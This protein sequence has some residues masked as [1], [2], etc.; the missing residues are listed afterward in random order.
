MKS[1]EKIPTSKVQRAS[2]FITTGAKIGRNYVKHYA[3]KAVNKNVTREELDEDNA[4][5]IYDSLSQLK[6]SALKVAQMMSMDKNM[7]P[8]AYTDRFTMSQYSAPPL[9]GPLVVKTFKKYFGKS[10]QELYDS[11]EM[12]A[13]NAASIGQV[14]TAYKDGK[15]L[16]VKIQY[17]GVADSIHSDLKMVK[18]FAVQILQLP[19]K[20]IDKYLE[21]VE[22]KLVEETDY[23]LELKRSQEISEACAHLD[24]LAFAHYY[25]DLSA[26]KILTMDWLPGK[27]LKEFMATNPSQEIRNQIGQALWD[28]YDFQMHQ[29]K[30]VHADPHP[31]NF[32]LQEDGTLGII[33]F[34]CI[35]EIPEDFYHNYFVVINPH[36]ME[37][38]EMMYQVFYDME[39]LYKHD[40][41]HI[42]EFYVGIFKQMVDL[43]CRP[44]RTDTFDFS[45]D[46]YFTEIYEFSDSLSNMKEIR[47]SKEA[48]GSKHSLY[49]N[50][51]YFGL[52][53]ILNELKAEVITKRPDWLRE[54]LAVTNS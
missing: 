20:D 16:A 45:N 48:R 54:P 11:F 3:K 14:H 36:L 12:D 23:D 8:K 26:N 46:E 6:G 51:T 15:K 35:K 44:F 41:D 17:P 29:L 47:E 18:P 42:K 22:S 34:G 49:I 2:K 1:Q 39:F 4:R 53:S 32:I 27:H 38:E 33:D 31:G 21:E 24:N 50:R 52:Y 10:P 25:P 28:F 37:N 19:N 30:A 9:S 43:L 40:P 5:D 13:S 7:L